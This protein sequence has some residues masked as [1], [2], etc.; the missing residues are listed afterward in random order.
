MSLLSE[1]EF[2][3]ADEG[4]A[5]HFVAAVY[6]VAGVGNV[7]EVEGKGKEVERA[8][9]QAHVD[10]GIVLIAYIVGDVQ[11]ACAFELCVDVES[12]KGIPAYAEVILVRLWS[13]VCL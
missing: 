7:V 13:D 6:G 1:G 5:G 2:E 3:A 12:L 4:E 8:V 11:S 10:C 9:G